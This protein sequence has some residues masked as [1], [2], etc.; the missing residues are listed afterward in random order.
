[1]HLVPRFRIHGSVTQLPHV[2][3]AWYLTEHGQLLVP[4]SMDKQRFFSSM[5]DV[6]AMDTVMHYACLVWGRIC[7]CKMWLVTL[8]LLGD[9]IQVSLE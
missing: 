8:N 7:G 6:L 5:E 1:M 9:T 3:T 2:F 4:I